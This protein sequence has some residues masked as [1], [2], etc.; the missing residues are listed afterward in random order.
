GMGCRA[1]L[2]FLPLLL[3][4]ATVAADENRQVL[5][6]EVVLDSAVVDIVYLGKAHECV[7]VTT[8]SKKLYFSADQG[9]SWNEIT[10]KVDPSP[11]WSVEAER[12]IVNPADKSVAVLQTKIRE[13]G[14]P[15][16][17]IRG[18]GADVEEGLGEAPRAPQLDLP[19]DRAVVGAR[20]LVERQLRLGAEAEG[21]EG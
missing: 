17:Y 8:K 18:L 4:A 11:S 9:Q 13:T 1:I 2:R 21:P 7:L 10:D 5:V 3:G 14:F 15:Y 20:L 16:I 6:K 19:P 12:I